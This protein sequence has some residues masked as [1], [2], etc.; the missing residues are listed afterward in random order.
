MND[1]GNKMQE[2]LLTELATLRQRVAALEAA[3]EAHEQTEAEWRHAQRTLEQQ[4]LT[5]TTA[6]QRLSSQLQAEIAERRR[7]EG[8][9]QLRS[10]HF[11]S[12]IQ[13]ASDIIALINADGIVRYYSPAIYRMLGYDPEEVVGRTLFGALHPDDVPTI[14]NTIAQLVQHPGTIRSVEYRVRHRDGSWRVFEAIGSSPE[15]I[16]SDACV[17]VNARDITERKQA[18]ETLRLTQFAIDHNDDMALWMGPDA[19]WIYVNE[20][21]CRTL[22]YSREDLLSMTVH[23]IIPDFPQEAWEEHW[24]DI[25]QN[26]PLFETHYRAKDGRLFPVEI[27]TN[28][29]EYQG[30]D[31]PVTLRNANRSRTVYERVK[32]AFAT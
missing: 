2:Q 4:A 28:Y 14:K 17:V 11:R 25:Q 8:K 13:Y 6:L 29:L 32:S 21:A 22:G 31:L 27:R 18:E 9:L 23:D 20:A 1:D 12:L 7:V 10:A 24:R 19:R 16:F 5:R 26:I 30:Q 3:A 15:D